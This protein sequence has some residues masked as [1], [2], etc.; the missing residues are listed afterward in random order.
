MTKQQFKRL[1]IILLLPLLALGGWLAHEEYLFPSNHL[2]VCDLKRAQLFCS[3][4]HV[5]SYSRDSQLYGHGQ[6]HLWVALLSGGFRHQVIE[7]PGI[8]SSYTAGGVTIPVSGVRTFFDYS[9]KEDSSIFACK[10]STEHG[11]QDRW[12]IMCEGKTPRTFA[13][14]DDKINLAYR[15]ALPTIQEQNR[16]YELRDKFL[17]AASVVTPLM[18]YCLLV[19]AFFLV[20]WV[21]RY[22]VHGPSPKAI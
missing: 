18:L 22:V 19:P 21:G 1:T 7:F 2:T 9:W 11:T 10:L 8:E 5:T 6:T 17:T 20:R 13:F 16:D 4:R 14:V 15:A 12:M 3:T